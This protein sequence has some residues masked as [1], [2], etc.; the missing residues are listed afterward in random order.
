MHNILLEISKT[1]LAYKNILG[2]TYF[3]SF[4]QPLSK[5]NNGIVK[6]CNIETDTG[7]NGI[8][9]KRLSRQIIYG[10][11]VCLFWHLFVCRG[12]I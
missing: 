3:I 2:I 6:K 12:Y 4:Q 11:Y 5:A 8:Y 10:F 9:V 1:F 7:T